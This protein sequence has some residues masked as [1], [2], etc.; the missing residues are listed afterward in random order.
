MKYKGWVI[1]RRWAWLFFIGIIALFSIWLYEWAFTDLPSAKIDFAH[2]PSG[3]MRITDRTRQLLYESLPAEGGRHSA[4]PLAKIPLALQQATIATED[5]TFYQNNGIDL[6]GILRAAW[7]NL[8]GG[9]TLAGGSTITQQVA[10]TILL[11]PTERADRSL[12]RKLRE[13]ILAMELTKKYPKETILELYLNQT[14]YGGMAYGVEAASQTY[15]G[16]PVEQ[17]DLAECALLAGLPQSPARYDPYS[18]VQSATERRAVVLSLMQKTGYITS[19]QRDQAEREA[20]SLTTT[21]YPMSAPHF[22]LWVRAQVEQMLSPQ[23]IEQAHGLTVQTTLDYHAQQAAEQAVQ[24]QLQ[25]LKQKGNQ[26]IGYNVNNAAVVALQPQTGAILAMVGSPNFE[27]QASHGSINMALAPRQPGSALKPFIYAAAFDPTR[28][29]PW[30]AATMILDVTHHFVTHDGKA[31][32]PQNYDAQEH[33]PV[34]ARQ[35]LASSLNIPAVL[36][37]QEV[38]I[39]TFF[40]FASELGINSFGDPNQYDLSLALGGGE[41]R[42]MDLTAAYG[43]LANGGYRVNPYAIEEIRDSQGNILYQHTAP[44]AHRVMDERVAW[45]ITDILSDDSAR[46][47]GF[48]AHSTLN[49][50][51]PAAVKTGTTTNFHDNWTLGY[52]PDLVVG[53]W[54]GNASHEAMREVNG[55]T[56]AAPI[57]HQTMREILSGT[58]ARAFQRPEGITATEVCSLSGLL[59]TSACPYRR[60]EWFLTGTVPQA[61]DNLYQTI[62][63]DKRTGKIVS[64]PCSAAQCDQITLLNLPPIAQ[65]W[66]HDH[67]IR[68]LSDLAGGSNAPL[69]S[70]SEPVAAISLRSPSPQT[71]YIINSGL[72]LSSQKLEVEAVAD[73]AITSLSLWVDGEKIASFHRAP[74]R[75]FWQ[76]APGKHTFWAEGVTAAGRGV[77]TLPVP[78]E[79]KS[80]PQP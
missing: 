19:E 15:F 45:V 31:Y 4:L 6:A 62:S 80:D 54:V 46:Q 24:Q 64:P 63:V 72:P 14:Y 26:G 21:P 69:A 77:R 23:Q 37:L 51:R 44:T 78:I 39:P 17:L 70:D 3:S 20:I 75:T 58:P 52:T 57:W 50:D 76:L 38:S 1:F 25:Q 60:M 49:L 41:V 47:L 22:D 71:S 29:H 8:S 33:G 59:P 18:D 16:K 40:K 35:A 74:Y 10:R 66:A 65:N 12:R 28:A 36:T 7:I 79:V 68:L 42:L 53:V 13:S 55:L 5:A 56:G 32:T 34:P 43:A 9:Q 61:M 48:S 27:D 73:P 67:S 2:L 30:T 11:S